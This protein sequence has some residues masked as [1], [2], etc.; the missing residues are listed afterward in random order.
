MLPSI[1]SSLSA[2]DAET[3]TGDIGGVRYGGGVGGRYGEGVVRYGEG[4]GSGL[5]A[6][7]VAGPYEQNPAVS[8]QLAEFEQNCID[9]SAVQEQL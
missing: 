9:L 6:F 3:L 7:V 4:V 2:F 8:L 5:G 1:E